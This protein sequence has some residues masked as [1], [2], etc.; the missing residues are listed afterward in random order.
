M[1][2]Q[3]SGCSSL[4]LL[5][6]AASSPSRLTASAWH[7]QT[8]WSQRLSKSEDSRAVG[9]EGLSPGCDPFCQFCYLLRACLCF[10]LG[11]GEAAAIISRSQG[12]FYFYQF[13]S[14]LCTCL[15][16]YRHAKEG[17]WFVGVT[18]CSDIGNLLEW[19]LHPRHLVIS[20]LPPLPLR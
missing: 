12:L 19:P 7:E 16:I 4:S 13:L 2:K 3:G 5:A 15:N 20:W 9:K 18:F 6:A 10:D 1:D 8:W 11:D 17:T 14:Q